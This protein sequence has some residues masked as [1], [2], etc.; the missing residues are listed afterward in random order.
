M[1]NDLNLYPFLEGLVFTACLI[2]IVREAEYIENLILRY[3]GYCPWCRYKFTH[4]IVKHDQTY[5][6]CGWR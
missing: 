5:G 3:Q 1:K 4:P 2:G 6:E